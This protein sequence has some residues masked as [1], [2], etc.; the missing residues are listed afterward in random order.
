MKTFQVHLSAVYI[1]L[2]YTDRVPERYPSLCSTVN[3][4]SMLLHWN[5][6]PKVSAGFKVP[7][8]VI[9]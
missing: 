5:I 3:R 8:P 1:H 2:S 4:I 9:K 6:R 7:Y